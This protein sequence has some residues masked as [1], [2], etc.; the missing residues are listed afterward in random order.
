MQLK[1]FFTVYIVVGCV[2]LG[3]VFNGVLQHWCILV[4]EC[5]LACNEIIPLCCW[6]SENTISEESR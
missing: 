1:L 5:L 4:L 2:L 3:F 6:L